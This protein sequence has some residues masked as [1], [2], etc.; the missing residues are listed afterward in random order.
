MSSSDIVSPSGLDLSPKP[1][2]PVLVSKRAGILFL[3][4][5]A[6]VAGMI[7][8]GIVTRGD[9]Q[10][11]L[12]LQADGT[13]GVTAATDA[14]RVITSRIPAGQAPQ[15][16]GREL[17]GELSTDPAPRKPN[18]GN[19]SGTYAGSVYTQSARNVA[20]PVAPPYRDLSPEERRRELPL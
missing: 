16:R 5:G 7:L 15:I 2:N 6:V 18:Q 12:G 3:I 9:R 14:G 20:A 11:K 10:L 8:Y 4:V 17:M 19:S 13:K 1:P